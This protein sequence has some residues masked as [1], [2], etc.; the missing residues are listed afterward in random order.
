[1]GRADTGTKEWTDTGTEWINGPSG[2]KNERTDG[3]REGESYWDDKD[4]TKILLLARGSTVA[5]KQLK[6]VPFS[7]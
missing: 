5:Y 2:D 1:M 3:Q 7:Y 6:K 4:E